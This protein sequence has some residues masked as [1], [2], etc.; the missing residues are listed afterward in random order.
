ME[1][2][3]EDFII[4]AFCI[5]LVLGALIIAVGVMPEI[6]KLNNEIQSYV[7]QIGSLNV[8]LADYERLA[9]SLNQTIIGNEAEISYW[10]NQ[11]WAYSNESAQKEEYIEYLEDMLRNS[12]TTNIFD[13]N[14]I[15]SMVM[16][17]MSYHVAFDDFAASATPL[18]YI[19]NVTVN[20]GHFL[21]N[22][23]MGTFYMEVNDACLLF[24][25]SIVYRDG[26]A[27]VLSYTQ[28]NIG[29]LLVDGRLIGDK[30]VIRIALSDLTINSG[31][32]DD[33]ENIVS[34]SCFE[35]TLTMPYN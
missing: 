20:C 18:L 10:R 4:I 34:V 16:L 1:K 35:I 28:W 29:Y 8:S 17:N 22:K 3:P 21:L 7:N 15:K 27:K 24:P 13:W 26:E 25:N 23:T 32:L 5:G 31:D 19:Q 6:T 33:M 9:D 30:I 12:Q 2:I 11:S 14:S